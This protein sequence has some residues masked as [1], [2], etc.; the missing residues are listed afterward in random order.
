MWAARKRHHL[1]YYVDMRILVRP[2]GEAT[3][4]FEA[5]AEERRGAPGVD[6]A[7]LGPVQIRGRATIE[8]GALV[9]RSVSVEAE[10]LDITTGLLRRIPLGAIREQIW[11]GLRQHPQLLEW[12]TSGFVPD[13]QNPFLFKPVSA[14]EQEAARR[15]TTRLVSGLKRRS[16]RRGRGSRSDD[17]YRDLAE[18]YLRV[19]AEHP[20][21]PIQALTEELR[22][23]RRHEH[24]SRN[25]VAAWI[26]K[27]RQQGW[28]TPA[29]MAKP[30][31]TPAPGCSQREWRPD[32]QTRNRPRARAPSN[33]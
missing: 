10:T 2:A 12:E 17:F 33:K 30:E 32:E 25:T 21:S 16:P 18:A 19:L 8:G 22:K 31:P 3:I 29:A 5:V 20:R 1:G 24:V 15:R 13:A 23:S 11:R 14:E 9:I 4:E 26:R 6:I 28:L 27:T 7:G